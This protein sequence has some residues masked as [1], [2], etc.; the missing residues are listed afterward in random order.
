MTDSQQ[1]TTTGISPESTASILLRE[2]GCAEKALEFARR[3]ACG[4]G[5]V[6]ELYEEAALELRAE[7]A[8][9]SALAGLQARANAREAVAQVAS[10]LHAKLSAWRYSAA[11]EWEYA[12]LT[13]GESVLTVGAS[14]GGV[15]SVNGQPFTGGVLIQTPEHTLKAVRQHLQPAQTSA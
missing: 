3:K 13:V 5:P 9:V 1:S 12:T 8:R 2:F 7:I 10:A 11:P 6:N 4:R 14:T 15:I